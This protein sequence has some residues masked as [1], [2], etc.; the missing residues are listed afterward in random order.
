MLSGSVTAYQLHEMGFRPD[1]NDWVRGVTRYVPLYEAKMI[2]Q[3]DHRWST[4]DKSDSRD[5]T[6][7]EKNDPDYEPRPRYW[8]P[9]EEMAHRLANQRWSKSWL[10][11]W[12]DICRSTDERSLIATAFPR[13]AVGN[14]MPLVFVNSP[15][16]LAA[17]LLSNWLS[18]TVDY[19]ARQKIGGTHLTLGYLTQ[20]PILPPS[21]YAESDLAFIVP[22]M[23]ELLYTSHSMAPFAR[24]LGY[25][26]QPFAWD[27]NRR[28]FLRAELD[29]FHARAYDLTRDE[30]RYILDPADVRGPSYPSETFRVLKTNEIRRFGEYRTARLVLAAY[31][32]LEDTKVAAQ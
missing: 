27:E 3:F 9:D 28:A 26:D 17:A 1:K 10:I 25:N 7:T 21:A 4:F 31:Y 29:A 13:A 20:F 12:R 8:V 19:V 14:T 2:H 6:N 22:R 16:P 5:V 11:G 24:D 30:L 15:P 18:M 23:L 32:E